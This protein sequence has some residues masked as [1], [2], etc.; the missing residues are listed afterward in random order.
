[1][2]YAG[3]SQALLWSFASIFAIGRLL[4]AARMYVGNPFIGLPSIISQHVI[5]LWGAL[6]A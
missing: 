2:E 1:M 3:A 5:C 4:H 6:V